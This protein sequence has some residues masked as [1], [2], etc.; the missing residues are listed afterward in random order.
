MIFIFIALTVLLI[1]GIM[2]SRSYRYDECLG[3]M[4]VTMSSMILIISLIILPLNYY[5]TKSEIVQYYITK[6]TIDQARE[7]SISDIE[8]AAL[9]TKIVEINQWLAGVK[10]WNETIF[11]IYI[12]DEIMGLEPLK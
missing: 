12:P 9:T 5:G 4:L 8:R 3:F 11:D 1:I 10:Y 2:L 7:Q 6:A